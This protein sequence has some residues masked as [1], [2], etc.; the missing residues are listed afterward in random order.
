MVDSIIS[1]ISF[2]WGDPVRRVTCASSHHTKDSVSGSNRVGRHLFQPLLYGLT[3]RQCLA[4][5]AMPL[6]E[7]WVP[8]YALLRLIDH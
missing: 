2:Q 7:M 5:F 4:G 8:L 6:R 3:I 1:R